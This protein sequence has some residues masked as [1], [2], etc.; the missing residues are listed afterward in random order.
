[1]ED[2]HFGKK[3]Y[4]A[5]LKLM[6]DKIDKLPDLRLGV[7]RGQLVVRYTVNG[8]KRQSGSKSSNWDKL[9]S[10]AKI[11][12]ELLAEYNQ[13][14]DEFELYFG[15]SYESIKS[16]YKVARCSAIL[17]P[18]NWESFIDN[19]CPVAKTGEFIADGHNLRSRIEMSTV[20][21]LLQLGLPYKYDSSVYENYHKRYVDFAINLEEFDISAFVEVMGSMDDASEVRRNASKFEE[22]SLYGFLLGRDWTIVCGTKHMVPDISSIKRTIINLVDNIA[23]LCVLKSS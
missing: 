20:E 1:M 9:Y 17:T 11:R 21:A 10:K 7:Q 8:K 15:E 6:E 14:L 2:F 13:L 16:Q 19:E 3:W 12:K 4:I 18:A 5:R 23:E 22:Y